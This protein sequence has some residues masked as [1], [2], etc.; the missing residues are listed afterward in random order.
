MRPDG[1]LGVFTHH[2]AEYSPKQWYER[3]DENISA[4][5]FKKFPEARQWMALLENC[6]FKTFA[7]IEV[8]SDLSEEAAKERFDP[9]GPAKKQWRDGDSYWAT[10]TPEEIRSVEDQIRRMKQNGT[11]QQYFKDNDRTDRFYDVH[12]VFAKAV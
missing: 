1:V 10:A 9:E 12:F 2:A 8:K 4:K 3:L 11:L 6:D 5:W 7:I